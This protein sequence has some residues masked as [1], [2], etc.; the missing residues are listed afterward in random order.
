MKLASTIL[1]EVLFFK[2]FQARVNNLIKRAKSLFPW[3]GGV[4]NVNNGK[5]ANDTL[6]LQLSAFM[7][8]SSFLPMFPAYLPF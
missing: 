7:T 6:R 5:H 3:P 1:H 2:A 8:L 4:K